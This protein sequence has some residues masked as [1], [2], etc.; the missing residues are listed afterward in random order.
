MSAS[1]PYDRITWRGFRFN[2]RT[3]A[4]VKVAENRLGRTLT[5]YQGSY[6]AGGVSASAGTHDGGGAIDVSSS[7]ADKTVRTLRDVGFAAWYRPAIPGLWT[8]HI[9]AIALA[10]QDLSSGAQ[11]QV[12]SYRNGR[13]GLADNGWDNQPYRP[14]PLRAFDYGEYRRRLKLRERLDNI[15]D[16]IKSLANRRRKVHNRLEHI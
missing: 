4:M 14:D 15:A 3:V 9:H 10:D 12:A 1:D 2:N 6:N 5:V 16:R 8:A 11:N 7:D 13:N